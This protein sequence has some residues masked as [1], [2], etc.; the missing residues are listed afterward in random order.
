[1]HFQQHNTHKLTHTLT[2]TH[3]HTHSCCTR[4]IRWDATCISSRTTHTHTRFRFRAYQHAPAR[5]HQ[6]L[7]PSAEVAETGG[8]I[9][10]QR[11]QLAR[12]AF[13]IHSY[14][15]CTERSLQVAAPV[16]RVALR[17]EG[18]QGDGHRRPRSARPPPSRCRPDTFLHEP[19]LVFPFPH[20]RPDCSVRTKMA[21]EIKSIFSESI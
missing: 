10:Q 15:V 8:A 6:C 16:P 18:E 2:H 21:Q 12:A 1:M 7:L 19:H 20:L 9:R 13:R 11:Y 4:T 5:I 14:C 3:T 17:R